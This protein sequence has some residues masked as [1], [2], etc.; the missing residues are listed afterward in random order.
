MSA[1][2][3]PLPPQPRMD[4]VHNSLT[5]GPT[6]PWFLTPLTAPLARQS[7]SLGSTSVSVASCMNP[8][9]RLLPYCMHKRVRHTGTRVNSALAQ[10]RAAYWHKRMQ[11]SGTSARSALAQGRAGCMMPQSGTATPSMPGDLLCPCSTRKVDWGTAVRVRDTDVFIT[12]ESPRESSLSL[13][14]KAAPPPVAEQVS[15]P[16][17]IHCFV[18][19]VRIPHPMET[20]PPEVVYGAP[21]RPGAA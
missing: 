7:S 14:N 21:S 20:C 1:V 6:W 3:G 10:A 9:M 8:G 12:Q 18:M 16:A 2:H 13:H 4:S 11:H 17:S 15:T 5:H 19:I